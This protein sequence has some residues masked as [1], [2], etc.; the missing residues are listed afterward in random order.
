MISKCKK[1]YCLCCTVRECL[2]VNVDQI[3]S[4]SE[5]KSASHLQAIDD[6]TMKWC[7]IYCASTPIAFFIITILV[8]STCFCI[9]AC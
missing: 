7:I 5:I 8:L 9:L 1:L 6:I 3:H 4:F 2:T